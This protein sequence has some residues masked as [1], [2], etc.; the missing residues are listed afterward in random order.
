MNILTYA[1]IIGVLLLCGF[2]Y[3]IYSNYNSM[4]KEIEVYKAEQVLLKESNISKDKELMDLR[5]DISFIRSSINEIETNRD[6]MESKVKD[7]KESFERE[8]KKSLNELATKKP[9]LIENLVNNA[10]RKKFIC[11]EKE[12]GAKG[13]LYENTICN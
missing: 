3:N 4:K 5:N 7:L 13:E 1:K 2:L 8:N 9:V 12:T 11:I 6:L 10:T